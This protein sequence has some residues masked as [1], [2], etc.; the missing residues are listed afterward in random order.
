MMIVLNLVHT[1]KYRIKETGIKD[2]D[3]QYISFGA[4]KEIRVFSHY[5][6]N[7]LKKIDK[8]NK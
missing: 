3:L 7:Q 8:M 6:V 5:S 2:I 1:L 4:E